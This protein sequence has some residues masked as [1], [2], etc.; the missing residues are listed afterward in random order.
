MIE[1]VLKRDG[2]TTESFQEEKVR[3]AL[4]LMYNAVKLPF[5][6]SVFDCVM[7]KLTE[8]EG[9][10]T[11]EEIQDII[12]DCLFETTREAYNAYHDYRSENNIGRKTKN[13]I[14][15]DYEKK[16]LAKKVDN[17]NANVDENSHSGRKAE[18]SS[19]IDK[20]FALD[21]MVSKQAK[22]NHINNESYIH[23]QKIVA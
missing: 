16:V 14:F 21:N 2:K 17:Q 15:L 11:V 19:V 13:R 5:D 4:S 20:Q 8:M 6:E 7:N 9:T 18:G 23:K 12:E 1:Q 22:R 3:R 10:I